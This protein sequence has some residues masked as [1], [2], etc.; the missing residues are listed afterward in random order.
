MEDEGDTVDHMG[1]MKV[2]IESH[3]HLAKLYTDTYAEELL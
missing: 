3:W 2:D 1:N